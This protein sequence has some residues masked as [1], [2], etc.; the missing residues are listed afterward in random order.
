MV[1]FE[2]DTDRFVAEWGELLGLGPAGAGPTSPRGSS[3]L[4][5][6]A[7][8]E[9]LRLLDERQRRVDYR[10]HLRR[11]R[12]SPDYPFLY[13]DQDVLNAILA[14]RVDARPR[15]RARR[16]G[17]RRTRRSRACGSPTRDGLRCAYDDGTEPY[18]LHHFVRKPWLEPMYH[19]IYSRLL[20]RLLLGA[21]VAI[22]SRS[23]SV[24][25]ANAHRRPAPGSSAPRVNARRPRPLVS[26]RRLPRRLQRRRLRLEA[27]TQVR[28]A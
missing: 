3:S 27:P 19:G 24:P 23:E 17:S 8:R 1:A 14:T 5:G 28:A 4:G 15:R 11:P 10:P 12:T 6:D 16:T 7:G 21:D 2:N 22:G 9:V 18:V 13:P 20:A 26:R 25:R